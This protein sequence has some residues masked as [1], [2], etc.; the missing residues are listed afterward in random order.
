V[1]NGAT[2][3][4]S[5][6]DLE[7]LANDPDVEF[8][9]P[10]R[11]ITA[12]AVLTEGDGELVASG[13]SGGSIAGGNSGKGSTSLVQDGTL[14][15]TDTAPA[16][17]PPPPTSNAPT[18][19]YFRETARASNVVSIGWDGM[20]I[21]VAVIDSGITPNGDFARA[22]AYSQSFV[23]GDSKTTDAFGHGT[24]VAGII[25]GTGTNSS[26]RSKYRL[27]GAAPGVT[28]INLRVLDANG[29]S[30]D[31]AVISAVR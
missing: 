5:A 19:D 23:P 10:D 27:G 3:S 18:L 7:D 1:V 31:S 28:L 6:K 2:Y 9:F 14:S 13:S 20:G 26:S 30:T 17:P 15:G 25:A 11:Q 8:I 24:H 29:A 22:I 4:V 16:P 21:G 12:T